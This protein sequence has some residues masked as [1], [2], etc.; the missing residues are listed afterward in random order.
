MYLLKAKGFK[1][2][3]QDRFQKKKEHWEYLHLQEGLLLQHQIVPKK[4]NIKTED[5]RL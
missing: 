3:N 2:K 5:I 1:N 4:E